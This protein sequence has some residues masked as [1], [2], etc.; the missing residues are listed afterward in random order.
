MT[1]AYTRIYVVGCMWHTEVHDRRKMHAA[2]AGGMT[3]SQ[4][5][6]CPIFGGISDVRR[7]VVPDLL[8]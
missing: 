1:G 8:S 3:G 7:G 4:T 2:S 5:D 6:G